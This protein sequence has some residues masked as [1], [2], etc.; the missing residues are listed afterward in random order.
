M[1]GKFS[2]DLEIGHKL[3]YFLAWVL[4]KKYEEV[5]ISQ[6]RFKFFDIHIPATGRKIECKFDKKSKVTPNIAVEYECF[7]KPSGISSTQAH[8]WVILLW[9]ETQQKWVFAIVEVE[10]L[11]KL[12]EGKR[13]VSGGDYYASRM[14]LVPKREL[15][16]SPFVKVKTFEKYLVEY[17]RL[18]IN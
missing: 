1:P 11:K 8:D 16:A 13:S 10:H 2:A 17:K 5:L 4:E 6:G 14:Y 18:S 9:D 15:L 12:C 3:E 7:G